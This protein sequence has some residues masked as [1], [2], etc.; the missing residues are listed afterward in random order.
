MA[1]I[2]RKSIKNA[3][4][5]MIED[6]GKY[7]DIIKENISFYLYKKETILPIDL[8]RNEDRDVI[9]RNK[10]DWHLL[11]T[12]QREDIEGFEKIWSERVNRT[13]ISIIMDKFHKK[14]DSSLTNLS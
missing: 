6:H 3:I 7:F 10:K 8:R 14:I 9:E 4:D 12:F 5:I 2:S 1:R 11:Y 13:E